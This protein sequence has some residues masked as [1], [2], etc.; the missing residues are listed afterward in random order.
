MVRVTVMK[1]VHK[2]LAGS[3]LLAV[4]FCFPQV[5]FAK[6]VDASLSAS[7]VKVGKQVH[8][9]STTKNVT[10][11]S[12]DSTIAYVSKEGV[13]TGK[14]PGEVTIRIKHNGYTTKECKLTVKKNA[15][16]PSIPVVF[17]EIKLVNQKMSQDAD[18]NYEFSAAIKNNAKQGKIKKIEYYY[19]IRQAVAQEEPETKEETPDPE[20]S[21]DVV[22]NNEGTGNPTPED[23]V[24]DEEKPEKEPQFEVN[25]V[26]LTAKS[27]EP[28][29]ISKKVS[30]MGDVSG[31][32]ASMKLLKIKL[33]TGQALY[34]Y[35][36]TAGKYSLEWGVE[37]KKAPVFSGWIEKGSYYNGCALRVCYNDRRKTYD[38][39]D[40]VKAA[41]DR[42]GAV[43]ISVDTSKI[44]WEKEGVYKVYYTAKDSAGNKAK[45]WAKVQ[46]YKKGTAE[47]I[48][49]DVLSSITKSKWSDEKKLRAIY[50]YVT[51]HCSY[52]DNG[53]HT[54]W[55][56]LAVNGIRYQSGDCF[57]YYAV[58]RLL[59]TRA[60]IP[61]I[62]IQRYPAHPGHDHWWNLVYVRV[63][64][65]NFDTT[66][67]RR[68]GKFCRVTDAQL[69]T[70]S[71][72]NTFS[73]NKNLYPARAT[74]K[75]S[76]NP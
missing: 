54:D 69:R 75:I 52:V 24:T 68:P 60:G 29:T 13:I 48:A 62:M 41:D 11:S 44:N 43:K 63:G 45:T 26:T 12:S 57:T 14:K 49:D 72:G 5:T 21:E 74:K 70:Y 18:G 64:G 55:R 22:Q 50:R 9:N 10:Y 76:P 42:D 30:C 8:V 7:T 56:S 19:E 4:L 47:E 58:S 1:Y 25:T 37:D 38:F 27:V 73:F 32:I 2:I 33:Y 15:R 28:G 34:V 36:A 6:T 16:Y 66:P 65:Y 61:N 20:S 59:I 31:D 46:V 40:H 23:G 17:D 71:T 39:K 53:S 67:R 3:I 51:G 35:D